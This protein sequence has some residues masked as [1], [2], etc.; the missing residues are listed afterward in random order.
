MRSQRFFGQKIRFPK[1]SLR[2]GK[3][4]PDDFIVED[5]NSV[6]IS[7]IH[8]V[9]MQVF[10]RFLFRQR[11]QIELQVIRIFEVEDGQLRIVVEKTLSP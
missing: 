11:H 7:C 5:S 1:I 4:F 9:G 10:T 8:C 3:D 2:Q 6:R